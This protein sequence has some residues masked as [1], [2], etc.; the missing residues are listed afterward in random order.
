MTSLR[1][2]LTRALDARTYK[3]V[4]LGPHE[5]EIQRDLR[6]PMDDGVELL[7]DLIRPVG[8]GDPDMPTVLIRGPYGRRGP[9]AGSAR[10]LAYEGFTV[11]FQS[12]R[13]TWGSAGTFTPQIDDQ[14]DGIATHRW[15]RRQPWFTGTLV[16]YGQSYM[17]FTQWAVAGK[18]QRDDPAI[19]P[20]AL[21]LITTMP[22][23]GAITWDNG[24]LA[25]RNALGWSRM[26][27][28]MRRGG[29]ALIG[30]AFPDPKL[31][32]AF[33]VLPLSKGD[34]AATG[35][36]IHWYQDWIEHEDLGDEYWTQQ[37]HT[38]SVPDVTAPIYMITGWYDIFLPWQ[39]RNYAQLAAVGR[40]PRLTIGP[41]GH[42]SRGMAAPAH[43]ETIEFY[44]EHFAA[45]A[46]TRAAPVRAYLTGADEWHDL[47]SWP[48]ADSVVQDWFP[49]ADGGLTTD[50]A[51]TGVT[52]YTYDPND[53][54]PAI[55]G[56]SLL[57]KTEPV[58]NAE[59]EKRSDVAV[60]RGEPLTD[61]LTLAGEPVARIRF[62]S[63]A[64]SYDVFVRITDVHPD[65]RSMTVCDAIRR[66]GSIGTTA[67]DPE[68][69][70]DGFREVEVRL[71]PTFH[72]FAAGHRVGIQISSGAHPRYARNPGS[73]EPASFAQ[74]IVTGRQEISHEGPRASRIALP[75]WSA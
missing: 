40:A 10:A 43:T 18:L 70:A 6:V 31:D 59:H 57:P 20:D 25:L 69:D 12:C 29:L 68:P 67:T 72:R 24:A 73:G 48:P 14:R 5:I 71:W 37:S 52:R 45:D 28:R 13:G 2:R 33:G 50:A 58:D 54:T 44:R 1:Q 16:T 32:K 74:D 49:S 21:V 26:M 53:P 15:V 30:I 3:G 35:E 11:L 64:P 56:P 19:A 23:F 55:G 7:A 65:G 36:P 61:S 17:G 34:S 8:G 42:T 41:W 27:H 66:I 75:V 63:S 46:S 47:P 9:L 22:D 38:A 60:F 51:T 39:L 62:R 4:D